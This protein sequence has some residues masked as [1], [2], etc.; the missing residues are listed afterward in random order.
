MWYLLDWTTA[1][2][3]APEPWHHH[4]FALTGME[5]CCL[6]PLKPGLVG[7]T[8]LLSPTSTDTCLS[9]SHKVLHD[10]ERD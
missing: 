10:T 9:L 3:N 1:C 5:M 6:F 8:P 2:K 7:E 4:V